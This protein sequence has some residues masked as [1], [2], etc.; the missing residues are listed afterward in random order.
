MKFDHAKTGYILRGKHEQLKCRQCHRAENIAEQN[1]YKNG[2]KNLNR[3]FLGLSEKCITCHEDQH[4]GQF[5]QSC[6][7]CH[8]LNKWKPVQTFD[9][10]K[11]AF[12]LS[13]GHRNVTCSKCHPVNEKKEMHFK[14]VKH[15]AC[16]DCHR[17]PHQA[18]FG[19]Q[20]EKCHSTT[21]WRGK[22]K[23]GF[24][25]DMTRY[26]LR[27]KHQQVVCEKCHFPGRPLKNIGYKF[28]RD[29][30]RDVHRGVFADH[31]S[32]GA[33][34][35][36]HTIEGFSPSTFGLPEHQKSGYPLAGSHL[37]VPCIACHKSAGGALRFSF[38]NKD[39][40]VCHVNPHGEEAGNL[41]TLSV[42]KG[43]AFCHGFEGWQD[44]TYDHGKTAFPLNGKHAAIK[45]SECHKKS[46][47]GM[48]RFSGLKKDCNIC[49]T[50]IHQ[51]QFRSDS[52]VDCAACHTPKDWLAENFNHNRDSRFKIEGAHRFVA[53]G[54]CHPI[55]EDKGVKFTRYKP[56]EITCAACHAERKSTKSEKI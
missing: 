20:C 31:A 8:S 11:T 18:K 53:C 36:C 6:E 52:G 2:N 16:R 38:T 17:D 19:N 9:H 27:G 51:G 48:L 34:E 40:Q 49:H 39:C 22:V 46:G 15:D 43:C 41:S 4:K 21:A 13:G 3:T 33:C 28:C 7:T 32:K 42:S 47:I 45:C 26:P 24:N 44:V 1:R 35:S 54:K 23:K 12:P 30:H 25:H 29:C 10:Q 50:D 55:V 56:L 5:E 37:A 14:P